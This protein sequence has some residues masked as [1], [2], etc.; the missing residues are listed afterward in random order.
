MRPTEND[1][2]SLA[3]VDD[4]RAWSMALEER[5]QKRSGLSLADA[6]R[7]VARRA[8]V[9]PG[10]L[11]NLRK[12]RLKSSDVGWYTRLRLLLIEELKQEMREHDREIK[13]LVAL[14]ADP[15]SDEMAQA[16]AGLKAIEKALGGAAR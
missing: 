5:E 16:E 7:I 13:M 14:G 15:R 2:L 8:N 4:A 9:A 1:R 11:E 6:R 3:F 12:R 10:T